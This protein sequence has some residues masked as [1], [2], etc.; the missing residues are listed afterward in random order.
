MP[1]YAGMTSA[2]TLKDYME[3]IKHYEQVY[4]T[5]GMYSMVE[6]YLE[7]MLLHLGDEEGSWVKVTNA[8]KKVETNQISG[9]L[10]GRIVQ[11]QPT[12]QYNASHY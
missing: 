10:P 4:E 8:G 3:R 6:F 11:V 9:F 7:V 1:D 5:L 2:E 12:V